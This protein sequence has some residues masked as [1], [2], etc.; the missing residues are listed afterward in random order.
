ME[1]SS[2]SLVR[3]WR[4]TF[5]FIMQKD[6]PNE[7]KIVKLC[8]YAAKNPVRIPKVVKPEMLFFDLGY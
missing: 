6:P 7:R 2:S 8:E 4:L 3:M 1:S 5:R